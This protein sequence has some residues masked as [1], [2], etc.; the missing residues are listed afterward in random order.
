MGPMIAEEIVLRT[1]I[2]KCDMYDYID[3]VL[4]LKYKYSDFEMSQITKDYRNNKLNN[5]LD[6]FKYFKEVSQKKV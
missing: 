3:A 1:L 2:E 4:D 6:N 5:S